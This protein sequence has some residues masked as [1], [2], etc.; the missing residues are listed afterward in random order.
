MQDLSHQT[1]RTL[2]E[3][4]VAVLSLLQKFNHWLGQHGDDAPAVDNAA[5][6]LLGDI[7]TAIETEVASH[8]GFEEASLFPLLVEN[9]EGEMCDFYLKEHREIVPLGDR[10]A[11]MARDARTEGFN[12]ATWADF[13]AVGADF[14]DRLTRHAEAEEAALVPL[15]DELLDAEMDEKLTEAYDAMR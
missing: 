9:G 13:R 5:N 8:F 15:L 7:A 10:V 3:E 2:H 6:R 1:A 12:T 4:H 14:A 11:A